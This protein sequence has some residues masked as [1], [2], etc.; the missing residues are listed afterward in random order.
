MSLVSPKCPRCKAVNVEYVREVVQHWTIDQINL[1]TN[2]VKLGHK[3]SAEDYGDFYLKCP[4]DDCNAE[5][6]SVQDLVDAQKK[7][8]VAQS[9]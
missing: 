4:N 6:S 2:S 7:G 3:V 8:L 5:F 1:D 9:G